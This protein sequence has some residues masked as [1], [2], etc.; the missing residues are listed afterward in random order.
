MGVPAGIG[1]RPRF[2]ARRQE[3]LVSSPFRSQLSW[4][5]SGLALAFLIPFWLADRAGLQRDVYYAV[6][7]AAVFSFLSLWAVRT[8]QPLRAFV[9]HR[10]RLM[11]PLAAVSAALLVF[12]VLRQSGSAHPDGWTFAGAILWRGVVYGAADGA[13]L[14]AFPIMAVLALFRSRP[15]RERTRR[16]VAAI[17]A[18][19]L[20][21]SLLFTAVYHLGYPD[22]RSDKVK[23]PLIGDVVWSAPTLLT[24]NPLGAPLVHIAL[25]VTAVAHSY[26]TDLF[27]P[28]HQTR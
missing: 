5:V 21:V 25:H 2:W 18:L 4:L 20:A 17:G 3:L 24:L 7:I 6:Y 22:F 16:S 19:A 14:S 13:L 11:L 12:I 27:L 8:Q 26:D 9:T 15:L 28:P 10:W 1:A 23:S